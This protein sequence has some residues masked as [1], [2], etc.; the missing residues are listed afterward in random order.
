MSEEE[1]H[2]E[3]EDRRHAEGEGESADVSRGEFVQH[4]SGEE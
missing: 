3:V 4:G 2:D 1:D